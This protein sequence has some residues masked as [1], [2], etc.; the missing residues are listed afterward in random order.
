MD[1]LGD[2]DAPSC[3]H[4]HE[5]DIGTFTT[6]G[7]CLAGSHDDLG[8]SHGHCVPSHGGWDKAKE[9]E[10]ILQGNSSTLT[11]KKN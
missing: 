4:H 10:Q 7:S 8:S 1:A 6:S 3:L 9:E 11:E 5:D 2:Q